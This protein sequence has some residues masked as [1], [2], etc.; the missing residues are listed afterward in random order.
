MPVPPPS[1]SEE[2]PPYMDE[3]A[4]LLPGTPGYRTRPGRSGLDYLDT[5]FEFARM[6]GIFLRR[7]FTGRLLTSSPVY[8][9]GM[10]LLGGICIAPA[11]LGAV[12]F[13]P[14]SEYTLL[15]WCYFAPMAIA[16]VALLVNFAV[17]L[18]N[19]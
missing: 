2:K 12:F 11:L 15:G 17:N 19:R 18:R 13:S 7:L 10:A 14:L 1:Q 6:E 8:L 16:G 3:V 4:F 5:Q 9:Y